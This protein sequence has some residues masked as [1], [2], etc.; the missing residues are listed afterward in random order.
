MSVNTIFCSYTHTHRSGVSDKPSVE[1]RAQQEFRSY[2]L[3]L[4]FDARDMIQPLVIEAILT[5]KLY[6]SEELT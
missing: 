3:Y 6:S 5:F 2:V 4:V 1:S